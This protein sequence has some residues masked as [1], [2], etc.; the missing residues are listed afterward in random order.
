MGLWFPGIL[1]RASLLGCLLVLTACGGPP[2]SLDAALVVEDIVT[3]YHDGGLRDGQ[4]RLLPTLAFRVRNQGDAPVS[5]VQFNAVF[6]VIGEDEELGSQL[7]R[8]IDRDGLAPGAT[9]DRFVLRS[10]FG[11]TGEQARIEMFQHQSFQDVQVELF[12]KAGGAQWVKLA[13][14]VVERQLVNISS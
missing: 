5:S 1:T 14:H 11:Y 13:E 6:R 3:G 9:T 2:P 7:I 4:R 12:G 10:T 8:G